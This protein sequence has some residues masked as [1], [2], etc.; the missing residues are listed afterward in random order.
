MTRTTATERLLERKWKS[1]DDELG[2]KPCPCCG[3]SSVDIGS[4]VITC[5][6]CHITT[7]QRNSI[8]IALGVWNKRPCQAS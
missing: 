8:T 5:I 2:V 4:G 7:G 1:K 6:D 3:S